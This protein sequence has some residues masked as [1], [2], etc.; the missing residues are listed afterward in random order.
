MQSATNGL[1]ELSN[2]TQ[3]DSNQFVSSFWNAAYQ[4]IYQAM[5][6]SKGWKEQDHS[7]ADKARIKGDPGYPLFALFYVQQVYGDIL[8]GHQ[9]YDRLSIS[10]TLYTKC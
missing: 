9:L 3:I 2:N 5:P 7:A 10:K 4:K 1:P 8:S 6:Y